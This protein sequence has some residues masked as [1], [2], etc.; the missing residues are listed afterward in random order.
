MCCC[1]LEVSRRQ[2]L[3][4]S[5]AASAAALLAPFTGRAEDDPTVQAVLRKTI[6]LDAHSH[7]AGIIF[8]SPADS[9]LANGMKKGGLSAVC[10]ASVPDGPVLGRGPT[11][12]LA[13]VRQP[14]QDE[15]YRYHMSRLDWMDELVAKH[16]VRRVLT[17]SDLQDAH[18]NGQPAIIGDIEGCDFL[19]GKLERLEEA[20][21]RGVRLVQLVHYTAN[22]LGDFQTGDVRHNGLSPFGA[23]VVR[24][25]NRLGV[26]VDI[27]HATETATRQA[28]KV[29]TRPL[30]LSHTA[31]AG[32]K[33]MGETRLAP[34][35]VTPDHARVV[36]DTG[37]V[38]ALWHFYP[39]LDRYV[40]GLREMVDVVG[41]D[42]V[43]IGTDQ[44]TTPG[45]VQNYGLLPQLT[46][47][48]LKK[49]FTP[50]ET[51]KIL[52]GNLVRVFTKATGA[53]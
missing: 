47:A 48:M 40:D 45:A 25:L 44:Q 10:L 18:T 35:Q 42:H 14:K 1:G 24:E 34:R 49:G 41:V 36:A 17:L 7:A 38:V 33:A 19:D 53:A 26:V 39:T 9:S 8:N 2:W 43:G 15:L 21:R 28:A 5:L 29:A 6:S 23:Q 31:L 46:A 52:G 3:Y 37:G 50:D 51:S 11:G 22:D 4:S 13:A 30:L 12:T 16:G 20:H 32:S 27:A